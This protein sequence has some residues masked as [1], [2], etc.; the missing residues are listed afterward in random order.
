MSK[1]DASIT[2]MHELPSSLLFALLSATPP[3]AECRKAVAKER[4]LSSLD[5]ESLAA[6]VNA[7][8][9]SLLVSQRLNDLKLKKRLPETVARA[10]DADVVH[11][12]LQYA[13]QRQDAINVSR[14]LRALGIRHA[15]LKGFAY[16]EVLYRPR[17]ARIGGDSDLLIDR[18]R[19]NAVRRAMYDL[20]FVQASSTIDYRDFRKATQ[21][22]LDETESQH[23]ELGQ[24]VKVYK[25][26]NPPPGFW[27]ED[28]VRRMPFTY[29]QVGD[30]VLFYSVIDIHWALHFA[31]AREAPLDSVVWSKTVEGDDFPH[32]SQEWGLFTTCFK[33]YFEA[34]DRVGYGYHHLADIVAIL[35]T[36]LGERQWRRFNELI[37]NYGLEAAAFYTL[38]AAVGIAAQPLVPAELLREWADLRGATH[39]AGRAQAGAGP[40]RQ[41]LDFGDFMP[42]LI[43]RRIRVELPPRSAKALSAARR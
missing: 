43:G 35:R 27:S 40:L 2:Q 5:W 26:V 41:A 39:P 13:L 30:G 4:G 8:A 22:Q 38:S 36:P 37:Q 25:I 1:D 19:V 18:H 32:L 9:L 11:A 24:F 12:R 21:R 33:L 6:E 28:F 15:F 14:H 31:F 3:T 23:Y 7:H 34:F 42:Y 10:W 16:R 29:Q 20:G 17:W